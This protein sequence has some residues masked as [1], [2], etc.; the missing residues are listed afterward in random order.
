MDEII[1]LET[2]PAAVA[3]KPEPDERNDAP[4]AYVFDGWNMVPL[5]VQP[6]A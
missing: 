6:R 3:N 4:V 1:E 5:E 2:A